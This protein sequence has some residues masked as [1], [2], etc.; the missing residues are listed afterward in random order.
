M[1]FYQVGGSVRDTLLHRV[2]RDIDISIEAPEATF[3]K[4]VTTLNK[5]HLMK[6]VD[7]KRNVVKA[8]PPDSRDRKVVDYRWCGKGQSI[9]DDLENRDFT[10]NSMALT[11]TKELLDPFNG[12]RDLL[13]TRVIRTVQSVDFTF[14]QD[15]V[16]VFRAIRFSCE[17]GFSIH[18][19]II[20]WIKEPK[21]HTSFLDTPNDRITQ[22]LNKAAKADNVKLMYLMSVE[23]YS[24]SYYLSLMGVELLFKSKGN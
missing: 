9:Q 18:P 19:E 22:E 3:A 16:R 5:T 2:P 10:I 8:I 13:E 20:A 6:Y 15:P 12:M 1:D 17:L 21:N 11:S 14:A 4:I 24:L 7:T 23:F